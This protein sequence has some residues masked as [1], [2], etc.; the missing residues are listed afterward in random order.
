MKHTQGN[1]NW[2]A[3]MPEGY[4]IETNDGK[5]IAFVQSDEIDT[6][7]CKKEE[8]CNARL[9]AAAPKLLEA[10]LEAQKLIEI[11]RPYMPKTIRNA[12]KFEF[13]DI[14]AN[15]INKAI[16]IATSPTKIFLP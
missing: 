5:V 15:H 7:E 4:S 12:D 10:L 13:E 1:W 11:A 8:S 9:I 2:I 3:Q 16:A 6:Q 14:S